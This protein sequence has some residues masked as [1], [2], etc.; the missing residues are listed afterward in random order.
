MNTISCNSLYTQQY[1]NKRVCSLSAKWIAWRCGAYANAPI[2]ISLCV[3][4]HC[5]H[6]AQPHRYP[7][8]RASI[9]I[10]QIRNYYGINSLC[11]GHGFGVHAAA[12]KQYRISFG[13][14]LAKRAPN[15]CVRAQI[16]CLLPCHNASVWKALV[17]VFVWKSIHC[18]CRT[19]QTLE[20]NNSV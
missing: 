14:Q 17:C 8:K 13:V 6:H 5:A 15:W 10:A 16:S 9:R 2:P 12:L 11:A 19:E 18:S 3:H 1:I 7:I 4:L 20:S